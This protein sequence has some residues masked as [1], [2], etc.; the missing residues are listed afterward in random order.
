MARF[1]AQAPNP[2]SNTI[3][4]IDEPY[5]ALHGH[6]QVAATTSASTR[7]YNAYC[8]ATFHTEQLPGHGR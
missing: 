8:S 1:V 3:I 4:S 7:A 6:E 5:H 2:L